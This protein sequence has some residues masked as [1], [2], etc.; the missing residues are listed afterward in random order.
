MFSSV[1]VCFELTE[2]IIN[3]MYCCNLELCQY[4]LYIWAHISP[5]V[6]FQYTLPFVMLLY[7]LCGC[8][9]FLLPFKFFT[10]II[11]SEVFMI[12]KYSGQSYL[13]TGFYIYQ[14]FVWKF[15]RLIVKPSPVVPGLE[16]L[17]EEWEVV[18]SNP[19][20]IIAVNLLSISLLISKTLTI[21]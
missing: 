20:W 4:W 10:Q 5:Q 6:Y 18:G 8:A 11:N 17:P 14:S 13:I 16:C 2:H 15:V 19:S 7:I 3:V 1:C 9:L 21:I 12:K